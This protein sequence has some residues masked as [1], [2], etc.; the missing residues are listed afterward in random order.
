MGTDPAVLGRRPVRA[1]TTGTCQSEAASSTSA[2]QGRRCSACTSAECKI[3]RR[4]CF[5]SLVSLPHLQSIIE[6]QCLARCPGVAQETID[7]LIDEEMERD[8]FIEIVIQRILLKQQN[9]ASIPDASGPRRERA[10]PAKNAEQAEGPKQQDARA[11][12]EQYGHPP[13]Y[14]HLIQS[15]SL[16]I[17]ACYSCRTSRP[18]SR[19]GAPQGD[20]HAN[21]R[22]EL[23]LGDWKENSVCRELYDVVS[24]LAGKLR[25]PAP[26]PVDAQDLFNN[27]LSA[28]LFGLLVSDKLPEYTESVVPLIIHCFGCRLL[29]AFGQSFDRW[30]PDTYFVACRQLISGSSLLLLAPAALEA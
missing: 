16:A 9:S 14:F 15:G 23:L 17:P 24:S 30:K 2:S 1:V 11:L 29:A 21:P 22:E 12:Q 10:V 18:A 4:L 8:V 3:Q 19:V 27:E 5:G 25:S 20:T 6:D 13:Y 7:Q 28:D 26:T